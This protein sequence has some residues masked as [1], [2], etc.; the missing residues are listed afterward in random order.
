MSDRAAWFVYSQPRAGKF[1]ARP[2]HP[3]GWAFLLGL[4]LPGLVGGRMIADLTGHRL[5]GLAG[6]LVIT[7]IGM[8]QL[9]RLI[10]R[11]GIAERA[12]D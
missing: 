1:S 5:A 10:R 12:E 3:I 4:P 6:A 11:R 9:F 2:V 7:G 8:W